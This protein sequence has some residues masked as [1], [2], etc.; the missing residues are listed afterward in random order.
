MLIR[1]IMLFEENPVTILLQLFI[2]LLATIIIVLLYFERS[3]TSQIRQTVDAI[4]I[5]PC[6]SCPQCPD[7]NSEGCPDLTCPEMGE[8]PECPKC[9]DVNTSCPT[10]KGLTVDDI[11]EA[12]FPGRNSG[13]TTHGNYFPLDGLGEASVEPAYSPVINMM[14]NYVGGDGVPA[15]ISLSDQKLLN[16]SSSIGLASQ[17]EP[18]IMN[19]QGVF[20]QNTGEPATAPAAPAVATAPATATAPAITSMTTAQN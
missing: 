17:K 7:L 4:D 8:C 20:S 11:V 16:N 10:H 1:Y 15:A 9:P 6:P 19:S 14:P 13:L 3:T 18:P 2:L 12:I 5:P